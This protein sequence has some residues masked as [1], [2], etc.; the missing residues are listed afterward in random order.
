M[1]PFSLL[2]AFLLVFTSSC[3]ENTDHL[4]PQTFTFDFSNSQDN[5]VGGFAD[6][7][8]IETA[9]YDLQVER[10]TLPTPLNTSKYA[11]RIAGTNHS[12]DLFMFIKKKITGLSPNTSYKVT[13]DV[14]FASNAPTGAIGVGGAPDGLYMKAGAMLTEPDTS[15]SASQKLYLMNINKGNQSIDGADMYNIGTI[16]VAN[17][18]TQFTLISRNN[19]AR[20]QT[21]KTDDKGEAWV[22]IGTDSAFEG[23]STLYY[24]KITINFK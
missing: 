15:W 4:I 10:T 3:T 11:L 13:F 24:N 6:F 5:W 20:P 16:G 12:D 18:T 17:N 8:H 19:N 14:E 21:L 1:K 23:R 9:G 7:H 2:L 22:C